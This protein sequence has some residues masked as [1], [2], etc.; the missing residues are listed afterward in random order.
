MAYFFRAL[1]WIRKLCFVLP[2]FV[3]LCFGWKYFAISGMYRTSYDFF[4]EDRRDVQLIHDFIP[5]SRILAPEKNIGTGVVYRRMVEDPLYFSVSLPRLYEKATVRLTY[6]N[7]THNIVE[8]GLRAGGNETWAFVWQ[9]LENKVIDRALK[10]WKSVSDSRAGASLLSPK[11]DFGSYQDFIAR[12][13]VDARVG[14][15]NTVVYPDVHLPNYTPSPQKQSF[16]HALRGMHTFYTYIDGETL[17]VTF[18]FQDLNRKFGGDPVTL[19]LFSKGELLDAQSLPDDGIDTASGQVSTLQTKHLSYAGLSTGVYQLTIQASDDILIRSSETAQR[20]FVASGAVFPVQGDDLTLQIPDTPAEAISLFTNASEMTFTTVHDAAFQ[21][22]RIGDD[23]LRLDATGKIFSWMGVSSDTHEVRSVVL[24]KSDAKI[25]GNGFFSFSPD[26]FF[27]PNLNI[28]RIA[29][30]HILED[31]DYLLVGNYSP[32]ERQGSW[33]VATKTFA[34]RGE[35]IQEGN[36]LQFA[37]SAPD[38]AS[39][40]NSLLI[41]DITVTLDKAPLSWD[42]VVRKISSFF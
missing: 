14:T 22:V 17:D 11:G 2:F 4:R 16:H 27:D 28:E 19:L 6:Q 25:S 24:P 13:P 30:H 41:R 35:N 23:T 40:G 12:F 5:S 18:S 10:Q 26:S 37:I 39:L 32:P 42:K 9:P 31:F 8:L 15:Y 20:Y 7:P 33:N 21:E 36:D 38:L 34:I 3:F 1:S 29:S